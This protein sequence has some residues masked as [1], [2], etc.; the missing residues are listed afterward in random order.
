MNIFSN[1]LLY[2]SKD[3]P[4]R[5][6]FNIIKTYNITNELILDV[7][8]GAGNFA[9]PLSKTNLVIEADIDINAIEKAKKRRLNDCKL[10]FVLADCR[11]LPF[12][13]RAFTIVIA[14]ELI[15]HMSRQEAG[16]MLKEVAYVLKDRG[17]LLLSTPKKD[18]P[19]KIEFE[20]HVY[21]YRRNELV[22]LLRQYF[23]IVKIIEY[24]GIICAALEKIEVEVSKLLGYKNPL[25]LLIRL[26]ESVLLKVDKFGEKSFLFIEAR[27][28]RV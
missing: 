10:D 25:I 13:N 12:R 1:L 28:E 4:S 14:F 9:I 22:N 8:G 5:L 23:P 27:F 24:G 7:G 26:L 21:E 19:L 15:E 16:F 3:A 18:R 11:L 6:R 20:G 2:F 17:L